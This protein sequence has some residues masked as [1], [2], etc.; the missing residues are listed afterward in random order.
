MDETVNGIHGCDIESILFRTRKH[1]PVHGPAFTLYLYNGIHFFIQQA[2]DALAG[3]TAV[4]ADSG[5]GQCLLQ[6]LPHN[7]SAVIINLIFIE[8]L[9]QFP[10][11]KTVHPLSGQGCSDAAGQTSGT[12]HGVL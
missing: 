10:R 2:V 7:G 1:N 11:R 6:F 8:N 5:I 9:I 3:G 12:S 4:Q